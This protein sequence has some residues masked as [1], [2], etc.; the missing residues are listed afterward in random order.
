VRKL[1]PLELAFEFVDLNTVVIHRIFNA[2]PLL[3]DLLKDRYGELE[4]GE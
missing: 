3:V 2:V 4:R 1:D